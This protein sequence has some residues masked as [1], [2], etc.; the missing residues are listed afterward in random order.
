MSYSLVIKNCGQILTMAG[1]FPKKGRAMSNLG[2][3]K[4]GFIV[5]TGDRISEVGQM[6]SLRQTHISNKTKVIDAKGKVVM[7]GLIDCHTHLVFA[8][9]R[10]NEFGMRLAGKSYLEI[11]E[12]GGGILSTVKA[13]RAAKKELL[14]RN[15]AQHACQMMKMGVTTMEAKSGYGLELGTE[16]KILRILKEL[17][18]KLPIRIVPTF[19]GAH[20]IPPEYKNRPQ[21]YLE[22][23]TTKVFPKLK[24]LAQFVDIF[25]E[26]K[27]FSLE[28]SKKYLFAA[29]KAGFKLKIHGEQINHLGACVMAAKMGAVSVDHADVIS[30]SDMAEL[31]KT[32]AVVVLL[33]LATLFLGE[34][35][36]ANGRTLIDAG[37]PVAIATDFNPG[38]SPCNNLFLGMTLACLKMG[39]TIEESIAAVTVNAA[40]ALD[41]GAEIGSIERIK[42]ADIIIT[43]VADYTEIPYWFGQNI[44][45]IVIAA[46]RVI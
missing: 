41:L 35:S 24:G 11:L 12:K 26:K 40:C 46:G 14:M 42:A 6:H 34:K 28:E 22:F 32:N 3:V 13:T 4:N 27:A 33:P 21:N 20:A 43:N 2:I 37:V 10:A 7:P 15:A 8:G 29:K 17:S 38:S 19:L 45:N 23:L 30:K 39:L 36:W 16:I 18:R 9:N 25:C 31:A 5:C 1:A 44:A